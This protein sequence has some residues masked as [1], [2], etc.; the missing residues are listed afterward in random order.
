MQRVLHGVTLQGIAHPF[1]WRMGASGSKPLPNIWLLRGR[2]SGN[3]MIHETFQ[4]IQIQYMYITQDIVL[5]TV[6]IGEC[7]CAQSD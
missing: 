2:C 7:N 1:I 6:D 5:K 4:L 3:L